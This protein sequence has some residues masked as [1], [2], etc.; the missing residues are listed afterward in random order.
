M[1][2]MR[3][4]H[5]AAQLIYDFLSERVNNDVAELLKRYENIMAC[6]NVSSELYIFPF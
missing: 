1:I 2:S 6:A 4:L 5:G 3:S